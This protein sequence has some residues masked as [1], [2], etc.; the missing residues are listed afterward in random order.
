MTLVIAHRGAS[1]DHEENTISAFRGARTQGADWVEFDV[2]RTSDGVLVIHHDPVLAHGP[3]ISD[4]EFSEMPSAVPTLSAAFAACEGMGVNVEIKNIPGE[5]GYDPTTSLTDAVAAEIR[6]NRSGSDILVTCFDLATLERF[7][8]E[9]SEFETGYLVLS[10]TDPVDE[11]AAAVR[12]GH[13]AIN[14]LADLVVAGDVQRAHEAGL[15][16]NTWTTD[17]PGRIAELAAMGV[18]GII[19]NVPGLA[20]RVLAG[21]S[22]P[23]Q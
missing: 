11:I 20:R 10:M 4:L 8:S 14:P 5:P 1:K 21:E 2:R 23:A 7:R 22:P 9:A 19:T 13:A 12:S 18:D 16:V 15:K 17:D 3:N 6:S